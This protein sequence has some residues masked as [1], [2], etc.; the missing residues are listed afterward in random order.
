MYRIK[1]ITLDIFS[2]ILIFYG[3]Y[4]FL[5]F[6]NSILFT[7]YSNNLVKIFLLSIPILFIFSIILFRLFIS[8][9]LPEYILFIYSILL[10]LF[11]IEV[12]F[13]YQNP[14]WS[15]AEFIMQGFDA[16]T[17]RRK[18]G[19]EAHVKLSPKHLSEYAPQNKLNVEDKTSFW[20]SRIRI[21]N[22]EM[23]PLGGVPN[24]TTL[25]CRNEEKIW[26]WYKSDERG[27]PNPKGVWSRLNQ[28]ILIVGD[29][30]AAGYCVP[31]DM[32]FSRKLTK[33]YPGVNL[34]AGGNGPLAELAGI[35]EY[36]RHLRPKIVLWFYFGND[37]HDLLRESN[38]SVLKRYLDPSFNQNL[39]AKAESIAAE[40]QTFSEGWMRAMA[41]RSKGEFHMGEV[42]RR[43]LSFYDI[44]KF[45]G[46]NIKSSEEA[47]NNLL[48]LFKNIIASA[49]EVVESWSGQIVFVYLPHPEDI[50]SLSSE[51][52][53]VI[54]IVTNAGIQVI[55][56]IGL[57]QQHLKPETLFD[58]GHYSV[59]GHQIVADFVAK[60][61]NEGKRQGK[62]R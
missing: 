35:I 42:L 54:T 2:L 49:K 21:D 46:I 12:Y 23:L 38:H 17:T 7:N 4:I 39:F 16:I 40:N 28:K 47:Q 58:S 50:T 14:Y 3:I 61:L 31:F 6:Y 51:S 5:Y 29:S 13:L 44:R 57:F 15:K 55:N 1:K 62:I 27:F 24:V 59:E 53:N 33:L 36:G 18:N 26:H 10:P 34:G 41:N 60:K 37:L 48:Q 19:E 45:I 32:T 30:F 25:L 20:R 52:K 43:V 9:I 22:E 11:L 56:P 8:R